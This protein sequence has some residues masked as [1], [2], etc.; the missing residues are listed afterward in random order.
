MIIS[1]FDRNNPVLKDQLSDLLRLT[2]P[3]EYGDSSAEEVEEMMNPERIAVVAVDQDELVGFIGA[4]PQYGITGWE[5][6]PL[7]V[8]SSRRKNQI[9][10]RLVNYLEK[11]VA[12]RGGITIYLGTDDLDHRT[13]LSQT[14][15]YE[16]TFDKVASIQNLRE[17]PYEFYEK[18]GYKIVGVLPNANG[19]DK[20]DIWMAKTIIPR[21]DS[22]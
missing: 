15:L 19:W 17:H 3:E 21:P 14:D 10:T 20:P 6:H 16:H 11:E 2:W 18:L 5:L 8:E 1:E 9:G 4:I 13:T 12:S 22:Q 7:V